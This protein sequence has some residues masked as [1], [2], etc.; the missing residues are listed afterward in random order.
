[1]QTPTYSGGCQCG[2]VSFTASGE[3]LGVRQ[4]WCRDCQKQTGGG[5]SI[6]ALFPRNNVRI[7][8]EMH[9]YC[10]TA[11]SGHVMRTLF[12]PSC[13]TPLFGVLNMAPGFLVI[14]V[15]AMDKPKDFA[16][17]SIIWTQSA[18]PW[19]CLDPTLPQIPQQTV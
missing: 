9:E 3:S 13:G 11:D 18:P 14:R 5:A 10:R 2:A 8:G 4:C 19:A 7:Q 16:P 12:C 1:M 15:G 6:N 17:Q